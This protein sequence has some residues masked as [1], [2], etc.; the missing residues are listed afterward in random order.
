MP[1][2][3]SGPAWPVA[4]A[5]RRWGPAL[6][7]AAVFLGLALPLADILASPDRLSAL[8]S[9]QVDAGAYDAAATALAGGAPWTA[10]PL[11]QPPGF[12]ATL[13]LIYA[14]FGHSYLA[15]KLALWA[16]LVAAT[17]LAAWLA[18]AVWG[19]R[20]AWAAALLT[21]T[22][23]ALRHYVG[24]VQYE[25]LVA[26]ELLATVAL[27]VTA[28]TTCGARRMTA[29]AALAGV[30]AGALALTRE[31]FVG[32][33]P[34]LALW[35]VWRARAGAGPRR[36]LAAGADLPGAGHRA[37]GVVVGDAVVAAR[38]TG[39]DVGQGPGHLPLG[40][41]AAASGTYNSDR[42]VEP[43]GRRFVRERPVA[44]LQLFGRKALYFWGVI[45]DQWNVPRPSGLWFY[46]ASGGLV[47]LDV[48]LP[49]ARGGWLLLA[50]LL[51][52]AHLRRSGRWREWWLV[53]AVV[54]AVC[55]A[56]VATL[57]SHR[58]AVPI[59]PLVFVLI[60]GPLTAGAARLGGWLSRA[61]WRQAGAAAVAL[62]AVALQWLGAPPPAV[63]FE[64]ASLDGLNGVNVVDPTSGRR[65]RIVGA[66]DGTR[67]ALILSDE[68]LAAGRYQ[69]LLTA[70][71]GNAPVGLDTAVARVTVT[72]GS[73][74]VA[75]REDVPSGLVPAERLGKIWVPCAW[76]ADGPVT[77][78]VE[79][80]GR[81]DLR[82]GEV[83]FM[84]VPARP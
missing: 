60:A 50:G 20:E 48:S 5:R 71:R 74:A 59:L 79:A 29:W 51:G 12:V 11:R 13:A 66:I 16:C 40:N 78:V 41:H 68:Y 23:P 27:V 65:L 45:R 15:A 46:R 10:I 81:T 57:S 73:G 7:L 35:L 49:L 63:A 26:A 43:A 32:V 62:L 53:P 83:V 22:A 4:S 33:I 75:C 84:R 30:A 44:A 72:D 39:D 80:L 24:T 61:T 56:H 17:A 14:V 38:P 6:G 70:G 19:R 47:P 2:P 9:L 67:S 64:A 36:A 34:V 58:F 55:A 42:A 25:V 8:G 28:A 21:A 1:Q 76:A 37:G 69:V 77:L 31:V 54:A 52:V 18:G 82:F 3:P